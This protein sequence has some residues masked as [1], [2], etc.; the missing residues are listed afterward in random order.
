MSLYTTIDTKTGLA[1][2]FIKGE[3]DIED[4]RHATIALYSDPD[5]NPNMA[6]LVDLRE[7]SANSLTADDIDELVVMTR[8][9]DDKRGNGRTAILAERRANIG[10]G[11]L[12]A[13]LLNDTQRKIGVFDDEGEALHWLYYGDEPY[14]AIA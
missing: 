10:I 5:F 7:G 13:A 8:A 1:T 9:M 4:I 3:L 6:I 14:Q 11:K 2:H 12:L